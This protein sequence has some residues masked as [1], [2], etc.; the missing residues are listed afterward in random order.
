MGS[1]VDVVTLCDEMMR[2]ARF[3][4]RF[5]TA[6]AGIKVEKNQSSSMCF[7]ALI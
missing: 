1:R 6:M 3:S 2:V 7:N 5:F 4:C